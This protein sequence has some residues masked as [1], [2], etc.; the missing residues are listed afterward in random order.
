MRHIM[1]ALDLSVDEIDDLIALAQKIMKHPEEYA[2]ICKGKKLATCFYEPS[3]RTRLSFE[4]AMLN[5]GGSVLGFSSADSSSASKG[6]SVSDTIRVIS[7]YADICAMRHP[8]EGA[9]LVASM[10]SSIPVINAGDGGHNHPTQT[11]TDLLR[12]KI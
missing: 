6:E 1:N 2:E 10:H 3:T 9:P 5:L 4:A 8:K 7:S 11:L 12:S